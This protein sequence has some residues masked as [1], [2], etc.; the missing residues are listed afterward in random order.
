VPGCRAPSRTR[1]LLTDLIGEQLKYTFDTMPATTPY[2]KCGKFI[3]AART[4]TVG[5]PNVP[6]MHKL[7]Y[8][9]FEATTWCGLDRQARLPPAVATGGRDP[10][11]VH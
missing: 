5:H 7:C 10:A 6:T 8:P 11:T 2:L 3:G 1:P 9:G 4:G